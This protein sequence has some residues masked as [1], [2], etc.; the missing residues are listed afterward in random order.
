MHLIQKMMICKMG[1][2]RVFTLEDL[3]NTAAA[4]VNQHLFHQANQVKRNEKASSGIR[5]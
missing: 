3:K 1:R 5:V 2:R 4:K